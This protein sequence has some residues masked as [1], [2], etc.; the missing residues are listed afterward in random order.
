MV[1]GRVGCGK[2]GWCGAGWGV[3][4]KGGACGKLRLFPAQAHLVC[5]KKD[6]WAWAVEHQC[7][8]MDSRAPL[9]MH[10]WSDTTA[11][12]CMHAHSHAALPSPMQALPI[13][14]G[15][16]GPGLIGGTFLKQVH[17]Q[18]CVWGGG[19]GRG[20]ICGLWV[21][22]VGGGGGEG[23]VCGVWGVGCAWGVDP[24]IGV[25]RWVDVVDL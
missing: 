19:G 17:E 15:L 4:R 7:A 8:C 16:I 5:L 1:W 3:G 20:G 25:G 18:V 11:H 12:A 21:G 22:G 23:S 24:Q 9:C 14:V 10:G 13:G 2:E 6:A